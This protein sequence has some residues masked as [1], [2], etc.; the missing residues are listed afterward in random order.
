[1]SAHPFA[2]EPW[3]QI[4][5]REI[6]LS[7][8]TKVAERLGYTRARVSQVVNGLT[9]AKPTKLAERVMKL[10]D[11]WEC[12]YL[13]TEIAADECRVTH[14]CPTPY[15]DPARLAQRRVC[16]SCTHNSNGGK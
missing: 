10:L 3:Y 12:P 15:H 9:A 2:G 7:S 4:L 5:M 14:S 16:R 13:N 6:E 1:M 11:R 8:I